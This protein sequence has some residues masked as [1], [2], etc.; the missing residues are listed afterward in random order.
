MRQVKSREI[1]LNNIRKA[2]HNEPGKPISKPDFSSP[3]FVN[4]NKDLAVDFAENFIKASGI[5]IFC[6]NENEFYKNL[7]LTL[8]KKKK[9]ILVSDSS[10]QK[11]V[12][13]AKIQ[14]I[15][16]N[17]DKLDGNENLLHAEVG[18][19]LCECL[20]ARTG[21]ILVSSAQA[22]GRRWGIWPPTHIVV[23][24]TSQ[25]AYDIADGLKLIGKKYKDKLPSM[26][27]L[28]TGPSRTADIE[29]TLVLGAHGPK[30][31]ILFLIE[32]N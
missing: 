17:Q 9:G 14:F 16:Y 31:L 26:I 6:E 19:T 7:Q 28:I 5:F 12:S 32:D 1:I 18:I 4:N 25:I 10:L 29:K 21:S 23:A 27:S 20:V 22:A 30:E 8:S 15:P 24:Y 13:A 2:L 3:I 11:M